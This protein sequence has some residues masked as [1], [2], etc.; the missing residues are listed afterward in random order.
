LSGIFPKAKFIH[1]KINADGRKERKTVQRNERVTKNETNERRC[2]LY[3]QRAG[4]GP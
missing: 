1:F 2:L 3:G 4:A